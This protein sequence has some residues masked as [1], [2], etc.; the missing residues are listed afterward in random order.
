MKLRR[1][2]TVCSVLMTVK[3]AFIE[4]TR[5][6][7]DTR[8]DHAS[9]SLFLTADLQPINSTHVNISIP[10][11]YSQQISILKWNNH[12][13]NSQYAAHGSFQLTRSLWNGSIQTIRPGF[14]MSR[15]RHLDPEP[16]HYF[17]LTA[18]ATYIK[19]FDVTQL[20]NIPV[21]GTYNLTLDFTR[22]ATLVPDGV[23][24]S[25]I[26]NMSK[27]FENSSLP[28]RTARIKSDTV[29]IDLQVSSP[30]HISR[31]RDTQS[32]CISQFQSASS[33]FKA[34]GH[35]RSLA[36]FALEK[37]LPPLGI[38]AHGVSGHN[39]SLILQN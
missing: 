35:A 22:P 23:E 14:H 37:T 16:G 31:K 10:N 12:F 28:L 30:V 27:S 9:S 21:D 26:L 24:L 25:E 20:F 39:S 19:S 34:R 3:A 29:S 7:N 11:D 17:N 6:A 2:W 13:Q 33:I 5:P 4:N 15:F 8:S 38:A 32:T 18:G 36:K 1:I